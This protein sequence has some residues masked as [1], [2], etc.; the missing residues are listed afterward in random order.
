MKYKKK[1]NYIF[2]NH[3]FVVLLSRKT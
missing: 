3:F 2:V 1:D